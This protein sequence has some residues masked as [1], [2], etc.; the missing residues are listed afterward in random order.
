MK[1]QNN[2]SKH[3]DALMHQA[4]NPDRIFAS[5]EFENKLNMRLEAESKGKR[6][7]QASIFTMNSIFKYAALFLI[8]LLNISAIL[9]L[10]NTTQQ[11]VDVEVAGHVDEY[12]PDYTLLTSLE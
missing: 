8:V 9:F 4:E 7:Q 1:S 10:R 3:I 11:D 6:N 5:S 12:F 2:I